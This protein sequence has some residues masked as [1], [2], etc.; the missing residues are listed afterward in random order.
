MDYLLGSVIYWASILVPA[1]KSVAPI[2]VLIMAILIWVIL[3][4]ALGIG[5]F[6]RRRERRHWD[7]VDLEIT[8]KTRGGR[9]APPRYL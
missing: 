2:E 9:P 4:V 5:V 3:L 8:N 1:R 7:H 6:A